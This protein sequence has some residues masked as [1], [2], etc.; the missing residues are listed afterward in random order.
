[1]KKEKKKQV[2][3]NISQKF[4]S[5]IFDQFRNH[6]YARE[7]KEQSIFLPRNNYHSHKGETHQ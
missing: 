1:M 2:Y 6:N 5:S 4:D 3:Q 7:K